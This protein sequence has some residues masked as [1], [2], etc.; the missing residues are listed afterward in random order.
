M[1]FRTGE[2]EKEGIVLLLLFLGYHRVKNP[3]RLL[4]LFLILIPSSLFLLFTKH[5]PTHF[6]DRLEPFPSSLG[7]LTETIHREFFDAISDLLPTAT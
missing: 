6:Q 1:S 5:S 2:W 4:I 7:V 3:S